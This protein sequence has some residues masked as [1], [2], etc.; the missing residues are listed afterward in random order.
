MLL[1]RPDGRAEWQLQTYYAEKVL[2]NEWAQTTDA[3]HAL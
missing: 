2:T 1:A 3:E